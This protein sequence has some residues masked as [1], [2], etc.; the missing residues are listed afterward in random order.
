MFWASSRLNNCSSET[1]DSDWSVTSDPE[2]LWCRPSRVVRRSRASTRTRRFQRFGLRQS[3]IGGLFHSARPSV[4]ARRTCRKRKKRM[5][6]CGF[7]CRPQSSQEWGLVRVFWSDGDILLQRWD[8]TILLIRLLF[9]AVPT[10]F[11]IS[12]AGHVSS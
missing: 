12:L 5:A 1:S 8:A 7:L 11:L 9:R 2:E 6:S 10:A 3:W 4:H